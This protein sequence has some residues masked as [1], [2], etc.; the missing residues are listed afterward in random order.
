MPPPVPAPGRND[1]LFVLVIVAAGTVLRIAGLDNVGFHGDEETMALAVRGLME[2]GVP[3]MPSGMFYPRGLPQIYLM[4]G[5]VTLFGESE[6]AYRLPSLLMGAALP[7]LS[8]YFGRR[9]LEPSWNVGLAAVFAFTPIFVELSQTARMYVFLVGSLLIFGAFV[10]EWATTGRRKFFVLAIVFWLVALSFHRL[11]VLALPVFLLPALFQ[12]SVIDVARILVIAGALAIAYFVADRLISLQY[13][14]AAARPEGEYEFYTSPFWLVHDDYPGVFWALAGL[15]VAVLIALAR[16]GGALWRGDTAGGV[17]AV[18]GLVAALTLNYTIAVALLLVAVWL[19]IA[20]RAPV[21]PV[22]IVVAVTV[23]A[24]AAHVGVLGASGEFPGRKAVGAMLGLVSIWPPLRTAQYSPALFGLFAAGFAIAYLHSA[25]RGTLSPA[26]V[27]ALVTVIVPFALIGA[28]AWDVPPRYGLGILPFVALVA[29][30]LVRDGLRT[31][32]DGR[33]T[34]AWMPG[35]EWSVPA[36]SALLIVGP[37]GYVASAVPAYGAYPDHVGAAAHVRAMNVDDD[38][39]IVVE[40]VLQH[41]YYLGNVDYWLMSRDVASNYAVV[42]GEVLV[43]QYTLTPI[44]GS[45]E[46]LRRVIRTNADRRVIIVGSGERHEKGRK[47][48][49]ANGI[50]EVLDSAELVD[51]FVG[52]DG[53]TRIWMPADTGHQR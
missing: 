52:R 36:V 2:S 14:S 50:S 41:T 4:A 29:L 44:I 37:I 5:S 1:W 32:F 9:W 23:V 18:G 26:I 11:A 16:P 28:A 48:M 53:V 30:M 51:V 24:A 27:L 10:F 22:A 8:V 40:D 7:L 46:E 17:A 33:T 49:R 3:Q 34:P 6:W 35:A 12:R 15:A 19:R 13:P 42:S 20:R 21:V 47:A 43:D 39:V 25:R 45:G 38:D 31:V